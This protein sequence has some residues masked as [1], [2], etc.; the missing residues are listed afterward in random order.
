[1]KFA[2][3]LYLKETYPIET[4]QVLFVDK[5]K[6]KRDCDEDAVELHKENERLE[7]SDY[8]NRL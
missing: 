6:Y 7:L 3:K 4:R 2:S 8:L 1:M 5:I